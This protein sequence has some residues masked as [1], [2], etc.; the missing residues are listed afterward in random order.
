MIKKFEDIMTASTFAEAGEFETA[1]EILKEARRVLLAMREG[2]VE[3]KALTY[4]LNTCK[5]IG[6]DIDILYLSLTNADENP[7]LKE[8]FRELQREGITYRLIQKNGRLREEIK[9][10]TDSERSIHFVVVESPAVERWNREEG[11][12]TILEKIKCPLVVVDV[13]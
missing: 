5:R 13:S 8:F 1:R 10:Y 7:L 4:A 9:K 6:A 12:S 2:E 11:L 3:R